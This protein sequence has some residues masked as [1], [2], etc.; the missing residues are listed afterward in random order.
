MKITINPSISITKTIEN[1]NDGDII[2]LENGVYHEKV[3]IF[4]SVT[5]IGESKENTII[6]NH[7]FFHKIMSDFN[8]CNTFRTYSVYVNV[9]DVTIQNLTIENSSTPAKKYGQAVALHV[10]G[11]NF[12]CDNVILSSAQDTLFTGPMPDDLIERHKGFL[13]NSHRKGTPTTQVYKNCEIRGDVDF[14]FG[15]AQALFID[16]DIISIANGKNDCNGYLCAPAHPKR[17]EF[18]YLFYRCNLIRENDTVTNVFLGRPWRDYGCAAFIECTMD[19]RINPEGFN[20]WSGT[21]RDQTSRFYE[22]TENI[23]LTNRV[24]WSHQLNKKEAE[25]YV[26]QFFSHIGYKES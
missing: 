13:P 8:E 25:E 23:D 3:E 4:K 18:G 14:I 12:T 24:K 26:K 22:Y 6:T 16:C 19:K 20:K 17:D 11:S 5:L 10:D 2:F 15:N 1:C 7:D 9:N 21:N